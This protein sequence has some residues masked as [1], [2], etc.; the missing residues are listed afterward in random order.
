MQSEPKH[1]FGPAGLPDLAGQARTANTLLREAVAAAKTDPAAHCAWGDL[2][3]DTHDPGEAA[4]S[5]RAA[6]QIDPRW[7]PAHAGLAVA[8]ADDDPA[9]AA[10][11]AAKALEIDPALTTARAFLVE[12][13]ADSRRGDAARRALEEGLAVNPR[14]LDLHAHAAALAFVEDRQSDFDAHVASALAVNPTFS[15]VF[16]VAA[17][18]AAS[19]YRYDDAAAL[20]R[21]AVGL[22]SDN[23]RAQAALGLHLLRVGEEREARRALEAAFRA[24]S[25]DL[26]TYNLLQML[27]GLD[28]FV[29]VTAGALT[30]RMDPDEAPVL[31]HYAVP[32]AADAFARMSKRYGFEPRGPIQVEIFPKHDDFAVRTAGLPGLIGAL[33]VCFGRVV[34]LDSPRARQPPGSFNWQS[35]L[36]HEMAHVFTMQLSN[37]RV[38][39]WLTEGISVWEEGRFRPAWAR[40]SEMTFARDYA[41][42]KVI[43]LAELDAGFTRAE[44]ISRA[45]FQASQ[46]VTLLV[47][48][49]GEGILGTLVR[50]FAG[51]SRPDDVLQRA[52]GQSLAEL[53]TAFDAFLARKYGAMGRALSV[54]KDVSVPASATPS[55]WQALAAAHRDRYPIQMGAGQ[56]LAAA[57][58]R[59]QAI[60]AFERAHALV[61]TATG[62][63]SP[64]ARLGEPAERAGDFTRAARE[65][66]S[67]LDDDHTNIDVAR[68]LLPVARRLGQEEARIAALDLITTIDPF[69]SGAHTERGRLA[70]ARKDTP[71][72]LRE[73]RAA[74][75]SGPVDRAPAHCDSAEA[76]LGAGQTADA[77]REVMAAL[78]LAPSFERAQELLLK[79]VD[80]K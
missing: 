65:W 12:N 75:A 39:R 16:T 7:A 62:S 25:F 38:P 15:R 24:D 71:L 67:L 6:L 29:P 59:D 28:T 54:P 43:P 60:V 27:D 34:S 76:L 68:R 40:D 35:T 49:S 78:E 69:D 45:Y 72:A 80:G 41:E 46:V 66:R 8:L 4:S 26:V 9:A 42:G 51:G 18:Y 58:V 17:S 57:G 44:S 19:R 47:E 73:F 32:L 1:C 33:G 21:K 37:Y 23:P 74:L 3:L 2:F 48:T 77:K 36:W 56:A 70:L 61:P 30:V 79:I 55:A 20:A 31:R 52:T 10:S 13:A 50:G 53:Q 22:E 14:A 64:R 5:F 11:A 63:D